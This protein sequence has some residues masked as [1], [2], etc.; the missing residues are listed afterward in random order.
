[1]SAWVVSHHHIDLIVS[2]AIDHA[3]SFKLLGIGILETATENN[4]Q[5]LGLMLWTENVRSVVYRYNLAGSEEERDYLSAL[6]AYS[7]RRYSNIRA[8]AAAS[9]L[10]CYDYQ[11]CEC[12]DYRES[13]AAL[14]VS[15]LQQAVGERPDD[16]T[17][18]PWGFDSETQ[19]EAA[20]AGA[21]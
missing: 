16:Y 13:A 17:K 1:M 21:A 19:V 10:A 2:T 14:F 7:F 3:V 6:N 11:A 20:Q 18:E 9:A 8:S 12:H 15:Q 4:A 5:A